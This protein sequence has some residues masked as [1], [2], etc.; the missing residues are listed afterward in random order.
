MQQIRSD[1]SVVTKY[2]EKH[3]KRYS[4]KPSP[5]SVEIALD[6]SACFAGLFSLNPG[7]K[8]TQETIEKVKQN[9]EL[10]V[11][12]PQREGGGNNYFGKNIVELLEKLDPL[13]TSAYIMMERIFP[14]HFNTVFLREGQVHKV[15]AVAELGIYGVFVRYF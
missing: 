8:T 3:H 4:S 15:E 11:M 12:K 7:E 5:S 2:V 9:P 6:I 14:P 13:Q 10:Y 1:L